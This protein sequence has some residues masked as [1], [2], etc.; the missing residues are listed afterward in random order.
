MTADLI[1]LLAVLE[2]RGLYAG[3]GY[4]SMFRFCLGRLRLS[5]EE[6]YYRIAVGRV[7]LRLPVVLERLRA[8][9]LTLTNAA[10]LRKHLTEENHARLLQAVEGR[11][12]REVQ[13][14]IAG[15]APR[16]DVRPSLRKVSGPRAPAAV[17]AAEDR[18]MEEA[19]PSP[20]VGAS[21]RVPAESPTAASELLPAAPAAPSL[22]LLSKASAATSNG[23]VGG[24]FPS[25]APS[26]SL[27]CSHQ[28]PQPRPAAPRPAEI[29]P[30]APTRY[31]LR[32]TISQG[33]YEKL[34]QATD[35]LRHSVPDGD[36]G[37]II[38]RALTLLIGHLERAKF[39]AKIPRPRGLEPPATGKTRAR[40]RRPGPASAASASTA[41]PAITDATSPAPSPPPPGPSPGPPL[42]ARPR[43]RY[44]PAAVRRAVSR[45]DQG[46]C[47]FV[48]V[49]GERCA[50]TGGL[51]FHH[52]VP[53][54]EGGESHG[55]R[56]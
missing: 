7:A 43:S 54:A 33:T 31:S 50:E 46:R 15:L 55:V 34:R 16:P 52:R 8:G 2:A 18:A 24:T 25:P 11:S 36:P 35:L 19:P 26:E 32:L 37:V 23:S 4:P 20:G 41:V 13:Q 21:G 53:F 44:I 12:K 39:A 3:E 27:P 49:S 10:L 42:L 47:A 1:A 51:E 6:A 14:L 56:S 40:R 38:D 29:R 22:P 48:A 17:P 9:T 28:V 45:R 5:E 30:L